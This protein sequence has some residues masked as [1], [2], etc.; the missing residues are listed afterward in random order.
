MRICILCQNEWIEEVREVATQVF[1]EKLTLKTPVS[2]TGKLPATHWL[3]VMFVTDEFWEKLQKLKNHSIM[4][5]SSPKNL[6]EELNLKII[7]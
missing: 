7:K 2:S 3:C 1:P 5:K 4:T 6:L